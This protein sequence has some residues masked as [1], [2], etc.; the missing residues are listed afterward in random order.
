MLSE[1]GRRPVIGNNENSYGDEFEKEL[2][3]LL[4]EQRRQEADDHEKELNIYRSG[5]AP[6]TVE[7]SM[8]AVGGLFNHGGGGGGGGSGSGGV[9]SAFA[10]FARNKS[11]GNGYLNED[12]LRSDPAYLSYYYSN[13]NL[14][15]RLP[16]PLLSREDWRYAQRLQG[17]SSAIG[18]RRKVNRNDGDNSGRSLFAMPPGF[19]SKKMEG[20]ND[21]DKLQGSVEW[22]GDGLIGLPGL[23]LG[24]KQKS[25]AEIFQDDLN[26]TTPVSGHPSRPASRN[27]FDENTTAMALAEDE[28]ASLRRELTPSDPVH[29]SATQPASYSY[30]AALG[31][32]LSRSSTP[33]PQRITRAPSPCPTP[34]GGG[35]GAANSEKR[36]INSPSSF[37]VGVAP[38]PN[39]S[40]ADL[41]SS[42]SS[43]N[44][45]NDIMDDEKHMSS[46]IDSDA[47]DHK[48]YLFNLQGGQTNARQQTYMN[49]HMSSGPFNVSSSDSG[50]VVGHDHSNNSSF[51]G[52][53]HH[54]NGVPSN[55]S[56]MK[57]SSPNASIN[58]GGGVLPQYQQLL[59]SPNSSFSNYGLS[60][61]PMSPISGQLGN[62]N[63]PPLFENAAAASAIGMDP[64]MLGASNFS[65]A[66]QNHNRL[67]NQM[68]GHAPYVDPLY[69]QYLRTAEYA[70]AAQVAALSDPSV[71][72]NYMGN[73]YMDL[74]Q[75]AYLGNLL[76]PQKSQY[77]VP[78]AGKGGGATSPH[79]YY[80]NHAFGIG[81][82]Y[83]GS[84]LANQV[85]PNS[86]GGPGSPMRH[87]EFNMRFTGGM[88]NVAA[89]S[90]VGPWHLDTMDNNSF[91]STL[92]EE[93]KSNKTKCFELPEIAG[94][95]VEFSAD[96]YG[97]R[98]IQ[99]KL[100]T[101]TTDEKNMVFQEIFPQ[102]LN[103]M[104]DVFG[105]YVIQKFFEHGMASQ[106]RELASKLIGH[107]LTLSLQMYGCRVIQKAIEVVDVDQKI[108]MV[109]ELD[110]HVMRCVRDQ[111][112]NH[113]I[114]KCI[115]SVPED[116]IQFIV[117]TFFDQVVTLSTHPYGC[118]VIQRV[119]EYCKDENTQSKVMEE[120]LGSV[121]ML[122]QDQY[123]NYVVQ[124]VLEHG[125]PHERTTIIQELAG[126]IVQ[127]SQ[128]KFA[129]NVVEKCLTFGDP[130]ERQLLVN[131][132]LGTTDENEPLQAMMKDQ[133]ANYVVQKVLETCSD[134]ERELIM[135]RIKVHLNAL[136]KYTYGKHIV[137]RVEKLVAA[138]ERR[139]A[140]QN[141]HPRVD[142]M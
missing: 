129:S 124:H 8:N 116:H 32:S 70:A 131:E 111:N 13:V 9:G 110:G 19:N 45:S 127:M 16:P 66:D 91:A 140:A 97:S 10:E 29:S 99:Q 1:L 119:L 141:S 54:I 117:S 71:D 92:L 142:V 102:A 128:Q 64:R 43:M 79:G 134:Q 73:S 24:A 34:I 21:M 12:E 41:V 82:S 123:G 58:V 39:E 2:G 49:K 57:G 138:G 96:Q 122:A 67:G 118:R 47:D 121:S 78:M 101:A 76:S 137:A 84:P 133:F 69:L 26:R 77:G 40:A 74:L 56:Y 104:T 132:M 130:S 7:G 95:V 81:L 68:S 36:N 112:G 109:G 135:S 88:R 52:E 14:N 136:K 30:A 46:R 55:N 108:N 17:G 53:L 63:L 87:G 35:R 48:N 93:F 5:S 4:R 80:A 98:F 89:G 126:K 37:N 94:H 113:V 100:E 114:Q 107:V 139:I 23:G 6:P 31:A 3:L 75:K 61:Y 103:L 120:I 106:R 18:D 11:G 62:S 50:G 59:D 33:D 25:L 42:L 65:G 72:R 60:G 22:G 85:L 83:P 38:H 90:V 15:P 27:A 28:L 51:Q 86:G 44:L 105:N 125:K 20:E 115:E